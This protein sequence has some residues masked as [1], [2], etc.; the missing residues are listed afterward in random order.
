MA[1]IQTRVA[2][3][4]TLTTTASSV[5]APSTYLYQVNTGQ[6]TIVKQLMLT[7]FTSSAKTVTIWLKKAN[8][9]ISTADIIFH[10]LVIN[11]NETTLV[12]LSLVMAYD[13]GDGDALYARASAANSVNI[14]INAVVENGD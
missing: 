1:F 2:G 8:V 9:T 3:P 12:N 11:A 14:V 10:D 13:S 7:N 4:S 5:V 6:T